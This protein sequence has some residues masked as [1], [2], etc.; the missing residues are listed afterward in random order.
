MTTS[1][2]LNSFN[3]GL[4]TLFDRPFGWGLNRYHEAF[5]FYQPRIFTPFKEVRSL[6]YNDGASNLSKML[7]EFGI[8]NLPLFLFF[9]FFAFSNR[10]DSATKIVLMPIVITQMIRGAGYFNGGFAL[11]LIL[12]ICIYISNHYRILKYEK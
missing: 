12:M 8:L 3:L 5:K 1:V 4:V 7:V 10:I 11:S 6:N 9:V 2:H